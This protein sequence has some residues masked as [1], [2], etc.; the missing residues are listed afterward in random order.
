MEPHLRFG[1][2]ELDTVRGILLRDG[3]PVA[4]G[5][6]ALS[7]LQA[8]VRAGGR[9]VTKDEL[10]AAAWPG[11][12]VEE[13]NLSVQIAALRKVLAASP[14]AGDW[15]ATAPRVGY[16]FA[17]PLRIGV[18]PA[19]RPSIAVLPFGNLSADAGQDYLADG[20]TEDI[21][22]ALARYRWFSVLARHCSFALRDSSPGAQRLAH[23]LGVRYLLEGSVRRSGER[24]RVAVALSDVPSAKQ[25]WAE[26]FE[27]A[28]TDM[29]AVQDRIVEQVAGAMEPELLRREACVAL[30]RRPGASVTAWD[31][32]R[33][34]TLAFHQVA[35]ESH[36]R[37]RT[38]FREAIARDPDLAQAHVWLARVSAG[39]VAYGWSADSRADTQEG[40]AAAF[41]AIRCDE[42]SPYAHYALAIVSAY[43][44]EPAQAVRAATRA[45]ELNP[46]FALGHLVLGMGHLFAGH[47]RE[48]I[49]ALEHGL[50]LNAYDPQN[51]VWYNLLAFARYFAGAFEA[52]L[53]AAERAWDIRPTWR[54]ALELMACCHLALG[55]QR[56]AMQC[57][58]R[59]LS[60]PAPTDC[61]LVPLDRGY[62]RWRE[63][64]DAALQSIAR[65]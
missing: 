60:L 63:R 59:M 35:R 31:L 47:P 61:L 3:S 48:A 28:L 22:D 13:A 12:V 9:I 17:G 41:A 20:I 52:A 26:R 7:V 49:G 23:E 2:F 55:D 65:P 45:L 42:R 10:M 14:E 19:D 32:V 6:R 21:I 58:V 51:F 57:A 24:I 64:M 5:G 39:I 46:S 29:F 44:D 18:V 30:A 40:L 56:A 25:I 1:A 38:L 37:A 8:L 33:Q 4:L 15:I 62:P 16:R 53:H 11:V 27:F 54:P 43:A 34:G 50:G 36:L